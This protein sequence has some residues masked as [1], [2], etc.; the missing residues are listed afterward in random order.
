VLLPGRT[1]QAEAYLAVADVLAH[2]SANEGVSQVVLQALAAGVPVVATDVCG[3]REVSEANVDIV[4]GSGKGFGE[5]V[6]RVLAGPP[7]GMTPAASLRPW[8]AEQIRDAIQTFH[9]E[10]LGT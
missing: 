10:V 9:H 5:R 4:P 8:E 3:L 7:A 2:A 1:D 6:G